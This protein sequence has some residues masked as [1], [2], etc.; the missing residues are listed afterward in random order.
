MDTFLF[1]P[2]ASGPASW[3]STLLPLAGLFLVFYFL[4]IRPTAKRQKEHENL[5]KAL[6]KGTK[7]V[8]SG[9]IVGTVAGVKNDVV[10]LKISD[11]VKINLL[12]SNVAALYQQSIAKSEKSEK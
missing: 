8:T 5:L 7:I 3:G 11:N 9:G 1:A 12:K 4:L 10:S 2:A 6:E